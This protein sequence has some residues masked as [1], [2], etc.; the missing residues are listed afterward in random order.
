MLVIHDIP[1]A[2]LKPRARALSLSQ[3]RRVEEPKDAGMLSR[4][5]H[6]IR[7]LAIAQRYNSP[8]NSPVAHEIRWNLP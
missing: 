1:P 5:K 8:G 4:N 3:G 7:E 6:R 2:H